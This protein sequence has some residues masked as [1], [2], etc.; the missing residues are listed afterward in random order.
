M[1]DRYAQRLSTLRALLDDAGIEHF[2]ASELVEHT[3]SG[4]PGPRIFPPR[5]RLLD[6]IV[7]TVKSADEIRD[8]WGGPVVV[9]S[10]YRAPYYND[11]LVEGSDRSQHMAF[12]AL[13]L[14]PADGQIDNFI[15]LVEEVVQAR[16][17]DGQ[18]IGLGRYP[19][20]IHIDTGY[21]DY[22]RDWDRT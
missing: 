11:E 22:Q 8:R 18:I 17:D 9:V 10:G 16:R 13:D 19:T 6:H 14:R 12:R 7:P 21:Y 20:F 5:E 3:R 4:W 1:T 15:D 2:S